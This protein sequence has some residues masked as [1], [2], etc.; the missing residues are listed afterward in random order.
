LL[1]GRVLA[2]HQADVARHLL[3][4]GEP[5]EVADLRAQADGGERV[6]T[7]Q[8]PQPADLQHPRRGGQQRCDLALEAVATVRERVDRSLGVEQRR[9]RR[10]P[11][12]R[13]RRQPLPVAGRPRVPVIEPDPVPEQQLREPVPAAHQIHPHRITRANQVPQRLFLI[14]RHPDRVEL[15]GQ[16]Q[17]HQ[18]LGVSTVGL[19]AI[20]TR[21]RDLAR[22]RNDALDPA[23][24]EL[25]R[26]PVT[27]RPGLIRDPHRS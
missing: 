11:L 5:L 21:A 14:A 15:P 17:P 1:P 22:R 8:A 2:G 24:C 7:A 20:P 3:G 19:H 18:V 26:Q 9:L 10:R 27:R 6:D 4:A 16:Q 25:A 23:L 12:Q 13:D